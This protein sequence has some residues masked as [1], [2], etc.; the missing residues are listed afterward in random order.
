MNYALVT[1]GSRGIGRAVCV[2]LAS[3]G[4]HVIV[5]Y[6]SNE[7]K[8]QETLG[9]INQAGGEG[10]LLKF[11]VSNLQE[12]ADALSQWKDAHKGEYISVVVNNAGIRKDNLLAL[13]DENDWYAVLGTTLN[14]FY[15]VTKQLIQPMMRKKFGR[16]INLASISGVIGLPGQTNY[17]ASKGGII[18][19]TKALAKEVAPKGVTVNAIAPGFINT[20]MVDGLDMEALVK[21]IPAGRFG[22]PEEVAELVAFLASTKSSYITGECIAITGGLN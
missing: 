11:D 13:M 15:N 8:A 12:T 7:A 19:A 2:K 4:F 20:D 14:G 21:T 18:A 6:V 16:V 5:N 10:S 17:S 1:G 3:E 9:L 22:N